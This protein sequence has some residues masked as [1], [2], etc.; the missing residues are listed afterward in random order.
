M[1]LDHS[2]IP[3]CFLQVDTGKS[4]LNKL[5]AS[6][7]KVIAVLEHLEILDIEAESLCHKI[8]DKLEVWTSRH[9]RFLE[10]IYA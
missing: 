4:S 9:S 3:S 5:K 1:Y 6:A 8:R 2:S 7:E 10:L